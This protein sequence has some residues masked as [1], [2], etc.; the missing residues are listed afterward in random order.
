MPYP[1]DATNWIRM[2]P[3]FSHLTPQEQNEAG[4]FSFIWGIFELRVMSVLQRLPTESINRISC[5]A[6]AMSPHIPRSDLSTEKTFFRDI[7]FSKDGSPKEL[8]DNASFRATDHREE[9]Q[10]IL[11]NTQSTFEQDAEALIRIVARLRNNFFHGFK[12]AYKLK[13]QQ[14]NFAHAS[15]VLIKVMPSV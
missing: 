9:I 13:G 4:S 12:W 15:S 7:F 2:Q 11:L 3:F 14:E 1:G 6:Y 8:W 10:E 5:R